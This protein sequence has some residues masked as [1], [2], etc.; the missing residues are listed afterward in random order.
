MKTEFLET[1][2]IIL[3]ALLPYIYAVYI[4][5]IV[6]AGDDNMKLSINSEDVD[7]VL[8]PAVSTIQQNLILYVRLNKHRHRISL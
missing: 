5:G 4:Y 3:S 8:G 1:S 7:V 6:S 2:E